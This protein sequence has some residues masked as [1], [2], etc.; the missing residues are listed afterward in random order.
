MFHDIFPKKL[1]NHFVDY[2]PNAE[3]FIFIFQGTGRKDDTLVMKKDPDETITFPTLAQTDIETL[4]SVSSNSVKEVIKYQA[5][6]SVAMNLDTRR[7][8]LYN[9]GHIDYEDM[10]LDAEGHATVSFFTGS[11][12]TTIA[13]EA[14]GQ[15]MDG[16]LITNYRPKRNNRH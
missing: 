5:R 16:T 2:A 4:M 1:D 12:A 9:D 11:K 14:N 6:D 15:M 10:Q 3:D 8:F 7:A 13:V